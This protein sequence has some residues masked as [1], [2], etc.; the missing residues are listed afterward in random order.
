MASAESEL[1]RPGLLLWLTVSSKN[2]CA[3]N[4]TGIAMVLRE[5]LEILSD[6]GNKRWRL[7]E[8]I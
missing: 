8:A 5:I 2:S 6:Y 4:L 7:W 3:R 1:T